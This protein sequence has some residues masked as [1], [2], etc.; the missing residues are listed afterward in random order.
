MGIR[1]YALVLLSAAVLASGCSS[2]KVAYDFNGLTDPN[3]KTV[4]HVNTTNIAI[5]FLGDSPV[6]GDA[7]VNRTVADFTAE[8]MT[9]GANHVRI[10]QS[11]K[12]T[13]WWCLPP[14]TFII[15]PVITEVAGDAILP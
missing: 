5:H 10:V 4:R 14:I 6:I 7:R 2:T 8:A 3:G 11:H 12:S 1:G 13:L 15:H 9:L